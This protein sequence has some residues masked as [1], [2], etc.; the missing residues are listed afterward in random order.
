MRGRIGRL[1]EPHPVTD[2]WYC[3]QV[4]ARRPGAFFFFEIRIYIPRR[5]Q[6]GTEAV[7]Y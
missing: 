2:F 3:I 5:V 4:S 7:A 6:R 1:A